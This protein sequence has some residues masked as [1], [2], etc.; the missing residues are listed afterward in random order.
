[1]FYER[2]CPHRDTEERVLGASVETLPCQVREAQEQH[3]DLN[4][5]KVKRRSTDRCEMHL[6]GSKDRP[7]KLGR[8]GIKA[9]RVSGWR[10][11]GKAETL[12]DEFG[13][14]WLNGTGN[15]VARSEKARRTS[16]RHCSV[17]D[18]ACELGRRGDEGRSTST[19]DF[20][21]R[22]LSSER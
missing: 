14:E 8:V 22:N 18:G 11:S 13:S 6:P 10:R 19:Q 9:T 15:R 5:W 7:C 1:M 2:F 20:R 3:A 17:L 21:A 16:A 12:K 4:F